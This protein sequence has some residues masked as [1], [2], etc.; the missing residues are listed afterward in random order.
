MMTW[1]DCAQP[2]LAW[3]ET[4]ELLLHLLF[5]PALLLPLVVGSWVFLAWPLRW[6][7]PAVLAL[8]PLPALAVS[9][10]YSPV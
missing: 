2:P 1:Q 8:G 10:I 9:T 5:T 4:R 6:R 3:L 7:S